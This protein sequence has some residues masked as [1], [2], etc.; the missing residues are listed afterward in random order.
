M[1]GFTYLCA[2]LLLVGC[3]ERTVAQSHLTDKLI[4][5][6][7]SYWLNL[8]LKGFKCAVYLNGAPVYEKFSLENE[9]AISLPVTSVMKSGTNEL[10]VDLEPINYA[11]ENFSPNSE[12]ILRIKLSPSRTDL[13]PKDV[14]LVWAHYDRESGDLVPMEKYQNLKPVTQSGM[15]KADRKYTLEPVD[16]QLRG[17]ED[18]PPRKTP[19]AKRLKVNFA[20]PSIEKFEPLA[21]Q[22][23]PLLKDCADL[24]SEL[25]RAY[26]DYWNPVISQDMKSRVVNSFDIIRA[27]AAASG[28]NTIQDYLSDPDVREAVLPTSSGA[29]PLDWPRS[30][31]SLFLLFNDKHNM[32]TIDPVPLHFGSAESIEN[33]GPTIYFYRNKSGILVAGY[34]EQY[35]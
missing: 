31:D 7:S 17:N 19:Y 5:P 16:M 13:Y 34:Q 35:H 24:R 23:A 8:N 22:N 10:T 2:F 12:S 25:T 28:Y 30:L 26:E 33:T 32:V 3:G 14:D 4:I 6:N 1:L 18:K 29:A 20:L 11:Q 21:W 27:S 15:I 9:I